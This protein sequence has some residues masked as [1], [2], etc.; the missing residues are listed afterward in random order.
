MNIEDL[1]F[2]ARTYNCLKRAKI[3]T[4]EEL[5]A[6]SKEG[7]MSV[8]GMGRSCFAEVLS[9]TGDPDLRAK[10]MHNPPR[11]KE[12]GWISVEDRLPEPFHSV[13]VHI[14]G[15]K[16]FPTVH[17]GFINSWGGWYAYHFDRQPGE[18]THWRPMPE[19][20]EEVSK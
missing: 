9:R 3:N 6:L 11:E 7:L 12:S 14:P 17:E 13:L 1:N 20:P 18:V 4:F 19:P 16:P 5:L 10:A 15:E 2:S 8:K